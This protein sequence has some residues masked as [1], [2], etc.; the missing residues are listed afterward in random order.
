MHASCM[1]AK[2]MMPLAGTAGIHMQVCSHTR[3][4]EYTVLQVAPSPAACTLTAA[5]ELQ[6]PPQALRQGAARPNPACAGQ[7]QAMRGAATQA[8]PSGRMQAR[9][10]LLRGRARTQPCAAKTPKKCKHASADAAPSGS[11]GPHALV[12]ALPVQL[13]THGL[14]QLQSH[15]RTPFLQSLASRG[16]PHTRESALA[17]S[18]ASGNAP[19]PLRRQH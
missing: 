9:M 17:T 10:R 11:R 16:V 14:R 6:A 12:H 2:G 15:C 19:M 5:S 7:H 8:M 13:L 4:L 1:H 18:K 3:T